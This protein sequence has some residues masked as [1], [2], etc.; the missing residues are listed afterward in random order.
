MLFSATFNDRILS[1]AEH[2]IADPI[3]ITVCRQD[4]SLPYIRQYYV[5]CNGPSS[6]YNTVRHS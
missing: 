5:R 2:L 6:K 1:F 4:Q 3:I